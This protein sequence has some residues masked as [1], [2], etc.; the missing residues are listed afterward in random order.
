MIVDTEI[1]S[2]VAIPQ[3]LK[4]LQLWSVLVNGEG[5]SIAAWRGDGPWR[6]VKVML[7]GNTEAKIIYANTLT[8]K[9]ARAA[10]EAEW[11]TAER[12]AARRESK[13][14]APLA[15]EI[16]EADAAELRG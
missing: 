4:P 2:A 7:E 14:I 10:A 13:G 11:R 15:V 1:E 9:D 16:G 8:L 5:E 6:R 12:E 3:R